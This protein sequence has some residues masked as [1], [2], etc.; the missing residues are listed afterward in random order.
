MLGSEATGK[1]KNGT[2]HLV[3]EPFEFLYHGHALPSQK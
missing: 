1:E 2:P 3:Y